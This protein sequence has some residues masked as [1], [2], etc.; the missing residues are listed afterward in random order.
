MA[1]VASRQRFSVDEIEDIKLAVAEACTAAIQHGAPR[2]LDRDRMRRSTATE[3]VITRA[4]PRPRTAAQRGREERIGEGG[5]TAELG[6]FL[7][8]ALMDEVEYTT[9]F[10]VEREL[11]MVKRVSD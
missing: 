7:I 6:V 4:R 1:A 11:V 3:C 8:R 10:T 5:R 9:T 2:Q